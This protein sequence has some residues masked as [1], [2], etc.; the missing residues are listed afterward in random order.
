MV[1]Q[2]V[3]ALFDP[4]RFWEKRIMER[5]SNRNLFFNEFP[6]FTP[7]LTPEEIF[8][9]G[10]FG[11]T[12]WRPINSKF[13]SEK[14]ENYHLKYDWGKKLD[15]KKLVTPWTEYNKETNKYGVSCG[16][17]LEEWENRNWINKFQPYG[18]VNWYCDFY[19]GERGEDDGWQVKRWIQTAGP[20]SRF[21]KRLINMI[22]KKGS[23]YDDFTISPKIRQTLQHWGYELNRR[24]FF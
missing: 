23:A 20:E 17:S 10:S 19:L 16:S 8:S 21:R 22:K 9:R 1:E 11:G 5:N 4:V 24:D 6:L 18:W 2:K 7:N 12:Y 15:R 14:L 3:V 13:Y